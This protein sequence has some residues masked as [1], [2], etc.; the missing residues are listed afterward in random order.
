MESAL[1]EHS[2]KSPFYSVKYCEMYIE[3]CIF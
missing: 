3:I 2:V 1:G